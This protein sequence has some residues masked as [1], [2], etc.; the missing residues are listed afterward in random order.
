[1][2]NDE[3]QQLTGDSVVQD[4]DNHMNE[5]DQEEAE[6]NKEL[7]QAEDTVS[8]LH[9]TIKSLENHT[10]ED[11]TEVIYNSAHDQLVITI[12]MSEVEGEAFLESL[13]RKSTSKYVTEKTQKIYWYG[14]G[15]E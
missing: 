10:Y 11:N 9:T 6:H 12:D 7:E 13:T 5:Q 1:M 14:R 15:G 2:D 4:L 3:W 8:D